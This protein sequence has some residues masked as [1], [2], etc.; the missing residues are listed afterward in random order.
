MEKDILLY[1]I[2]QPHSWPVSNNCSSIF[3]IDELQSLPFL[4]LLWLMNNSPR[5]VISE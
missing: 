5:L 2:M 1:T 3:L 4:M